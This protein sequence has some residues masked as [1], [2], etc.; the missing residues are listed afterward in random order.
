MRI[1]ATVCGRSVNTSL[2]VTITLDVFGHLG[3]IPAVTCNNPRV[4]DTDRCIQ[5]MLVE[6]FSFRHCR[7]LYDYISSGRSGHIKVKND[8]GCRRKVPRI[9]V[10]AGA[11]HSSP[12]KYVVENC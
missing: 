4:A 6:W 8:T 3:A 10:Q 7:L 9:T 5:L 11:K 1:R 2:G 12:S